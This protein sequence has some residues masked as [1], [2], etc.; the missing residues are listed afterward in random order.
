VF[1]GIR[2]RQL[3]VHD[4][5]NESVIHLNGAAHIAFA[6]CGGLHPPLATAENS[7]SLIIPTF[8]L[9]YGPLSALYFVK[10]VA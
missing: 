8:R 7:I 1:V 10:A 2:Y 5:Q 9:S 6:M 3:G 4:E